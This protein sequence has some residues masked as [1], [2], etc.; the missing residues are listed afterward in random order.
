MRIPD[1]LTRIPGRRMATAILAAI[2]TL[3]GVLPVLAQGTP[4][5]PA[6]PADQGSSYSPKIHLTACTA[7]E[8]VDSRC[9]TVTVPMDWSQPEGETTDL[10][11][12]VRPADN[13]AERIGVML[14]NNA[15]GGSAIEL[16][17]LAL[18]QGGIVGP[19]TDYVDLV[20]VDPRG[21]GQSTPVTCNRPQRIEGITHFPT[22]PAGVR[23]TGSGQP[24][25]G[26]GMP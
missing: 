22:E 15:S 7:D 8:F 5:T 17:R 24:R 19:L 1:R 25:A 26:Q 9:G 18:A 16:L 11:L 23:R 10:A 14:L 13:Q 12:V 4:A 21:V 3:T 6:T 20:A 2:I